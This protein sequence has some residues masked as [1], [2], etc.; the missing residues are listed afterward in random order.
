MKMLGS[1]SLARKNKPSGETVVKEVR[2]LC[3]LIL[4]A[5][6]LVAAPVSPVSSI[7]VDDTF[8]NG[9]SQ[10]QDLANN[11][12]W[13]FNG[14]TNN[15][16]LEQVGSV[17]FDITPAGTSSEAFW[18]YFT[19]AGSPIVL[20]VGDKLSVSMTFSL[21]GFLANGQDIRFGV[22]DSQGTRNST[23]LA[24]EQNDATFIGH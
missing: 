2:V 8:A 7:I 13:L 22:L 18:A 24:G 19:N 6:V 3:A 1:W 14:R 23:N 4:S 10:V 17:T 20:A 15:L 16:R 11:S 21:A 12:L 5:C 9:N